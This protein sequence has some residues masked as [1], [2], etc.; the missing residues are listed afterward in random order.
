MDVKRKIKSEKP[1]KDKAVLAMLAL[2][3]KM[4][5]ADKRLASIKEN[6]AVMQSRLSPSQWR[7]FVNKRWKKNL[8]S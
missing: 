8:P 5:V 7:A 2:R 3:Q 4:D 1:C 6:L